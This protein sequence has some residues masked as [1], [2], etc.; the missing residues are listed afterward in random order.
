LEG[1]P[2]GTTAK[3]VRGDKPRYRCRD[4]LLGLQKMALMREGAVKYGV[5]EK[6]ENVR[7]STMGWALC[8]SRNA[9]VGGG[10]LGS[11]KKLT[12]KNNRY[13]PSQQEFNAN[14]GVE[15]GGPWLK[16]RGDPSGL[17]L[18]T[19]KNSHTG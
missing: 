5:E 3:G 15:K 2:E 1:R 16:E 9:F 13:I 17:S 11:K 4:S 12:V 8:E 19:K 14:T 18:V 10:V 7:L 6:V